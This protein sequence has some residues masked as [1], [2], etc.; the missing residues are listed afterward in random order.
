M[1]IG[2]PERWAE[3]CRTSLERRG[4]NHVLIRT[5]RVFALAF[6]GRFEEAREAADGLIDAAVASNNPYMHTFAI[7]NYSYCLASASSER[8][9][10]LC[11]QGLALAQD[12]GNRYTETI[13]ATALARFEAETAVTVA[14]IDHLTLVIRHWHDSGNTGGLV[15]PLAMLGAFLDRL[16][17]FEAAATLAGFSCNPVS[18]ATV[19][20][21]APTIAHLQET[22]GD[23]AYQSFA[24][25]GEAM[26]TAAIVAYAYDQIDQARTELGAVPVGES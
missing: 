5:C 23:Q 13:L 17:R 12:S 16:G 3:L 26:T 1:A 19:P 4:D 6:A 18:L 2:Q 15:G 9:L 8:D 11:R 24:R 14:A 20:E 7:A 22:L 21:L 25:T 10:T